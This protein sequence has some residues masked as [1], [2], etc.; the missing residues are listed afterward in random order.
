VA[1]VINLRTVRKRAKRQQRD[2]SADANRLAFGQQKHVRKLEAA[3]QA[4]A[5]RDLD[6]R[7]IE[8]GDRR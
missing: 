8:T 6:R 1:E 5:N 4:K 7:R 2:K 3:R